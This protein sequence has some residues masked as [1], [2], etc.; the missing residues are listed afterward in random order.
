MSNSPVKEEIWR[1]RS[2][3]QSQPLAKDNLGPVSVFGRVGEL[4]REGNDLYIQMEESGVIYEKNIAESKVAP[5]YAELA[6]I[7]GC[8]GQDDWCSYAAS[9]PPSWKREIKSKQ[10]LAAFLKFKK[11]DLVL[12]KHTSRLCV[13]YPQ[14]LGSN[15]KSLILSSLKGGIQDSKE[16][17]NDEPKVQNI[18]PPVTLE[19]NGT[20]AGSA[21]VQNMFKSWLTLLRK[22]SPCQV[23]VGILEGPFL[24]TVE[25]ENKIEITESGETSKK[26][27]MLM[28]IAVNMKYG[29]EVAKELTPLWIGGPLIMALY[30]T[31]VQV[32]TSLYIFSFRQSVKLLKKSPMVYNYVASGKLN[33]M[34]R[35]RLWTPTADFWSLGYIEISKRI[36]NDFL[37]W[38]V[39]KYMDYVESIWPSYCKFIRFLKRAN[40]I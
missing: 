18:Q 26:V 15:R 33:E 39:E 29:G 10:L 24:K 20:I 4:T 12:L 35:V 1:Y 22:P 25:A 2:L 9:R 6:P 23:S 3:V 7:T 13:T 37:L 34:I 27:C 5:V 38:L 14:I 30:M 11:A 19:S 28:Y 40:F 17:L 8:M 21:A 36:W 31:M 32:I 16:T